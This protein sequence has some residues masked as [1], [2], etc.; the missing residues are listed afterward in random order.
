MTNARKVL[1]GTFVALALAAN[2]HAVLAAGEA[3][4]GSQWWTQNRQ[5]ALF[6][7][8]RVL[9]QGGYLESFMLRDKT[10]PYSWSLNGVNALQD[11]QN[12]NFNMRRGAWRLDLGYTGIP[13]LY[14]QIAVSPYTLAAPG[15]YVLPDSLQ[16]VNQEYPAGTSYAATMNDLLRNSPRIPLSL[17]SD[18]STARLRGR[19]S[20]AL[21]LDVKARR[22]QRSGNVPYAGIF[23]FSSAIE[24]PQPIDQTMTDVDATADWH[25]NRVKLQATAGMSTFDDAIT[26]LRWDNPQRYTNSATGSVVGQMAMP[27]DNTVIRGNV[28]LGMDLPHHHVLTLNAGVA[29]HSQDDTFLPLTVNPAIAAHDSLP[30]A[31]LD[32]KVTVITADARLASYASE[33][34]KGALRV[35]YRDYDNQTDPLTFVGM[36][37]YDQ[38]FNATDQTSKPESHTE[39][40][41]GLDLDYS[42]GHIGSIGALVEQ[43]NRER[44]HREV[45][46]D[47]ELIYGVNAHLRPADGVEVGARYK[48][49]ERELDTFL[50][51]DYKNE[52]GAFIEQPGL[53]RYDVANRTR[54]DAGGS[55]GFMVGEK[56]MGSADYSYLKDEYPDTQLGLLDNTQNLVSAEGTYVLNEAWSVNGGYTLGQGVTN[57]KSRESVGA[58]MVVNSDTTSWTA[59]LTDK[60]W[61]YFATVDW[62]AQKNKLTLTFGYEATRNIGEYDLAN[63]KNTAVDVPST[64]QLRQDAIFRSL[65]KVSKTMSLDFRYAYEEYKVIDFSSV[66]VPRVFPLTGSVTAIYF[67]DSLQPYNS[68]RIS[69]AARYG[70]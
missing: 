16:R 35:N 68:H 25:K 36:S 40:A 63:Y 37:P 7:Q 8:F 19:P 54:D 42:L 70:F 22:I 24:L 10:G 69:I 57:Q 27:P 6:Q 38:S 26:A 43:K 17:Q 13:H 30:A 44:T 45:E 52:L 15:V 32:A 34:L 23:G 11:D 62:V 60:S 46:K 39:L 67:G 49:G 29:Q 64:Y 28:A 66:N 1:I 65:W 9:P 12:Y 48:H 2:A 20:E 21:K 56:F 55:I 3:T 41:A 18:Y 59:E 5:E 58:T 4:F 47:D 53:R 51:E 14:S 50:D 61:Y 31:S 33:K